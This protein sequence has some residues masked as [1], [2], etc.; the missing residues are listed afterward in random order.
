MDGADNRLGRGEGWVNWCASRDRAFRFR[1]M[2]EQFL[3]KLH[4]PGKVCGPPIK[5]AIDEI[6][7]PTK[8]QPD[9]RGDDKI[10]AKVCP[11][12]FMPTRKIKSE[13]QKPDHSAMGRHSAFPHA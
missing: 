13:E 7:A 12:K 1:R 5:L 6:G 3:R 4:R 8:E 11:G 9:R 2:V 10:V